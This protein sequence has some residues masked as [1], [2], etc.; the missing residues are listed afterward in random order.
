[1]DANNKVII[2]Y[3]SDCLICKLNYKKYWKIISDYL[4]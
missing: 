4:I 1:M 2:T 3:K